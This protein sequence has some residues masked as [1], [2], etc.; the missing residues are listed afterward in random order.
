[1]CRKQLDDPAAA[2]ADAYQRLCG[3]MRHLHLVGKDDNFQGI[4]I[5]G[6]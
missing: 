3:D 1:V 4:E 2:I 6:P 5:A